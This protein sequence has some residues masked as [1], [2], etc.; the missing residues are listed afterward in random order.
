MTTKTHKDI[1]RREGQH[2]TMNKKKEKNENYK[3][4]MNHGLFF[5]I[6]V[7]KYLPI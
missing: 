3:C 1:T 7:N 5:V 4:F 2:K 6:I